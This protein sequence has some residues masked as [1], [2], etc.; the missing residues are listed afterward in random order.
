MP[1]LVY[2]SLMSGKIE[3][4]DNLQYLRGMAALAV[5]LVYLDPPFNSG[6]D[7]EILVEEGPEEAYTDTWAWNAEAQQGLKDLEKG[8]AAA[9]RVG[10]FLRAL[11]EPMGDSSTLA[12]LVMMAPRL[13]ELHRVLKQTGSLYLHCDPTASHYLK[14][15][16][17]L[18]FGPTGVRGQIIWKRTFAHNN[19]RFP[20]PIHDVILFFT[21]SED[22]TWNV[23]RQ[24]LD[25]RAKFDGVDEDGRKWT[26]DPLNA[27]GVR[28]GDSGKPWRGVD[29]GEAGRHWAIAGA[30][31]REYERTTG[32]RLVGTTSE[33]L[34]A[35]DAVGLV[36]WPEKD[37]GVPRYKK[38]ID[39]G[40]P[41]QDIWTDIAP[42]NANSEEKEDFEGQKPTKL[43]ERIILASSNA[44]DLV[45]DPFLG[46]GTT[47]VAAERLRR[48]WIGLE[49]NTKSGRLAQN[50]LDKEFGEGSAQA[51]QRHAEGLF[52]YMMTLDE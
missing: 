5:D 31:A 51:A 49:L 28:N 42:L 29:P 9:K 48:N 17:D 52:D 32:K 47:A 30:L 36:L 4:G 37:G 26:R 40:P 1:R 24:Q 14:V 25:E 41:L 3:Y 15:L 45:L 35:L 43:L 20:G 11:R 6:R 46:S 12:Y 34:D 10:T 13:V 27:P 38:Y 8:G 39:Q 33:R 2:A 18:I 23:V 21:K 50:R 22:Y 16:L 7:Y 19:A 44:G